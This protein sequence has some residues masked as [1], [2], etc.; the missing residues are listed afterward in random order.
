MGIWTFSTTYPLYM[1]AKAKKIGRPPRWD[2]YNVLAKMASDPDLT[3]AAAARL[4]GIN[5]GTVSRWCRE[6]G[7]SLEGHLHP[8]VSF[9]LNLKR[10]RRARMMKEL[11]LLNKEIRELE[12]LEKKDPSAPYIKPREKSRKAFRQEKSELQ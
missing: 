3:A 7:I 12:E 5:R 6:A 11:P 9:V 2:K 1:G 8:R 4:F 10:K